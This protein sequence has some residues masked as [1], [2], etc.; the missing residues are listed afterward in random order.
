MLLIISPAKKLQIP[1]TERTDLTSINFPEESKYLISELRKF[2]IEALSSLMNISPKLA[3]LNF[4]R[5]LKWEYP[6]NGGEAGAALF[7][8]N[9]DVYRGMQTTDFT[10]EDIQFTQNRLRIL[11]GLYGIIKPLDKIMPYRLEMGTKLE[12]KKGKNL[13]QFWGDKITEHMNADF[14]K[15][16]DNVLINLASNEYYKVMNTKKIKGKIITPVFKE[17]KGDNY[18][19]VAIHAKHARGLMCR[20]IIKNKL[21]QTDD[22]KGFDSENYSFNHELSGES[23]FVFTR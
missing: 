21:T 15:L 14:Q 18:K 5:Y 1:K 19:V 13:Y 20:F 2:K 9:G 22:L 4:E 3:E 23:E 17:Q 7:M 10:E 16:N 6:F 11:S 8:F 12:T